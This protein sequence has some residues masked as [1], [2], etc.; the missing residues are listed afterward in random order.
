MDFATIGQLIG[1]I[2]FPCVVCLILIN[3][4]EKQNDT[5]KEEMTKITESLNNNTNALIQLT[6][7]LDVY[8]STK[9]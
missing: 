8:A 3:L 7:K 2:G 1:S 5:H 6:A 4:M 9:E